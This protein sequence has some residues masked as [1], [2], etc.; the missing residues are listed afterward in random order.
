MYEFNKIR[1]Y[2]WIGPRA[3]VYTLFVMCQNF[4]QSIFESEIEGRGIHQLSS[5]IS[6]RDAVSNEILEIRN[7]LK[8]IGYNSQIYAERIHPELKF[9]VKKYTNYKKRCK[10]DIFIYHQTVG[11]NFLDFIKNLDSKIIMI[12]HNITPP[13]YFVG[14]ND[15]IA[16]QCR[17]GLKQINELKKTVDIVVAKSEY[18]KNDLENI[19]YQNIQVMPILL[20]KTKYELNPIKNIISKYKN[21]V[22]ILYVGR[23]VKH[24]QVDEIIKIF[25]YYNCNINPNSNLFL[26]GKPLNFDDKYYL[27]LESLIENEKIKNVHFI[28]GADDKKLVTYYSLADVFIIMSKHEGFCVPIVECMMFKVPIIANNSSAIPDTLGEGGILIKKE[29]HREIAKLI[30]KIVNDETFRD[31]L[32]EKQSNQYKKLYPKDNVSF[33]MDILN[34]VKKI[35]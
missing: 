21:S 16:N 27:S 13:E 11:I 32:I 35:E 29:T 20:D 22:N 30:D 18:S 2:W 3:I 25:H 28:I 15:K 4:I 9:K 14:I 12:Y 6:P 8:K 31:S 10:D 23:I 19:G 17:L 34:L 26:I 33:L 24:K 5:G 1:R 7:I